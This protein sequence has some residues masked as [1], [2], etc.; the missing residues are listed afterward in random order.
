ML[1]LPHLSTDNFSPFLEWETVLCQVIS[2][3]SISL[4]EV[5]DVLHEVFFLP[6]LGLLWASFIYM[7]V[8]GGGLLLSLFSSFSHSRSSPLRDFQLKPESGTVASPS[9]SYAQGLL[10]VTCWLPALVRMAPYPASQGEVK[11]EGPQALP[12]SA[13]SKP[14]W[15]QLRTRQAWVSPETLRW[16]SSTKPETCYNSW[17]NLISWATMTRV[18]WLEA[19]AAGEY[20]V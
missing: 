1:T 8:C 6:V 11:Q 10:S 4:W 17:Q 5:Y 15:T 2:I 20:G 14:G 12:L 9:P 19:T 13:T 18:V 7:G 16:W 3:L